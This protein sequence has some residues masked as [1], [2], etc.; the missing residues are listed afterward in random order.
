M[1]IK[2]LHYADL[3]NFGG[4]QR[5]VLDL[6][7]FQAT[8][9]SLNVTLFCPFKGKINMNFEKAKFELVQ[10]QLKSGF[11]FSL[12]E[13]YKIFKLFKQYDVIHLHGFSFFLFFIIPM[14]KTKVIFTEHGTLQKA[15]QFQSITKFIKKRILTFT[16][17]RLFADAVV[18]NSNWLMNNI[19]FKK[20]HSYVI[21]NGLDIS[22]ERIKLKKGHQTDTF[23]ILFVG[24]LVK[25][26]RVDLLIQSVSKIDSN[27]W[28]HLHIVGDGPE[29]DTLKTLANN[30]LK[31]E[32]FTFHGFCKDVDTFYQ[33]ADLFILPTEYEP[34]GLVVIEAILHGLPVICFEDG[35]GALEILDSLN[36]QLV[37]KDVEQLS[38]YIEYWR[39]NPIEREIVVEKL[40]NRAL[41]KFSQQKMASN[42]YALYEKLLKDQ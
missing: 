28:F 31:E 17:L 33:K 14:L 20:K 25:K 38:Q 12:T 4:I 19:K 35:G 36:D 30:L 24:R 2:V 32:C 5:L 9:Q 41:T 13:Y 22:P 6:G 7:S 18:Y 1:E 42:Y 11:H 10:G 40:K 26:K 34:F 16:F 8:R 29:F 3:R 27:K 15:N 23:N 37:C 21:H 39:E